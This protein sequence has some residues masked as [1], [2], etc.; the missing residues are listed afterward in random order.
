MLIKKELLH[1]LIQEQINSSKISQAPVKEKSPQQQEN[2]TQENSNEEQ[3]IDLKEF[4]LRVN[5]KVEEILAD[6]SKTLEDEK[7]KLAM[8]KNKFSEEVTQA[9]DEFAEEKKQII[10]RINQLEEE[11]VS[12]IKEIKNLQKQ[13]ILQSKDFI[14]DLAG[15]LAARV[16][17]KEVRIDPH[18]LEN[19]LESSLETITSGGKQKDPLIILVNPDDQKLAEEFAL[20]YQADHQLQLKVKTDPDI[21]LGSCSIEGILGSLDLNFSSQ[22]QLFKEKMK[23]LS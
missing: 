8:E 17:E 3:V 21:S 22:L 15:D 12:S 6:W 20:S 7:E 19:L 4:S 23:L 16:I 18:I 5:E 14:L 13:I 9:Q 11:A 1:K 10:Q 2:I